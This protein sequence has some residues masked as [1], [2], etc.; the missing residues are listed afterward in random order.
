MPSVKLRADTLAVL[1]ALR[2]RL[3]CGH[4]YDALICELVRR[5][6]DGTATALMAGDRLLRLE[7][8]MTKILL[9]QTASSTTQKYKIE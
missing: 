1:G 4:S 8:I 7:E 3:R 6:I 2:G 5:E 9:Q